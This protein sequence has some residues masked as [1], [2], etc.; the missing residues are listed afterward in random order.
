[1]FNIFKK[2]TKPNY[3]EFKRPRTI[4]C[5]PGTWNDRSEIVQTIAENN[6]NEYLFAGMILMNVK[7]NKGFELEVCE[8]DDRMRESFGFAGMVNRVSKEFLDQIDKHT[9][10][11]Y[12]S[13]DTGNLEDARALA[14]AGKAILKSGGI[15]VKVETTGKAFEKNHWIEI[16]EN[17]EEPSLYPLY[18]LDSISDGKG[19]TYSCGMH[20]LGLKDTIIYGE[21]FQDSVDLISVFGY[22]QIVDK[23][24]IEENQTFSVSIEAPVFKIKVESNQPNEGDELFENPYG[25]WKLERE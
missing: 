6:L 23:P 8:R 16:L 19:T 17:E 4:L 13:T 2:K 18:V 21:E 9:Y 25:M 24:I 12:L 15:G 1:M 22:Y 5:I 10:V 14:E 11:I 20:N 7:T 3:S